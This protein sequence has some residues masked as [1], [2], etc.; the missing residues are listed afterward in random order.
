VSGETPDT[1]TE[2]VALPAVQMAGRRRVAPRFFFWFLDV[3][4][5][6]TPVWFR[7]ILSC[8]IAEIIREIR[9]QIPFG[10][11]EIKSQPETR[12]ERIAGMNHQPA[13]RLPPSQMLGWKSRQAGGFRG[14]HG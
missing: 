2:T 6:K 1:A 3:S 4:G 13:P 11:Q 14:Y 5:G 10:L 9:G 12:G 8:P 7:D